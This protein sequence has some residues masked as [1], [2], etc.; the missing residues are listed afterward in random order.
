MMDSSKAKKLQRNSRM[1]A[2][3]N[4]PRRLR[5]RSDAAHS[6]MVIE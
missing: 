6:L 2:S 4:R 3:C 1:G 5:L